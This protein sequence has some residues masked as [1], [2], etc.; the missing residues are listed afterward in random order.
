MSGVVAG[1][2][3]HM[4]T[5]RR[6]SHYNAGE[7]IAVRIR[8][9]ARSCGEAARATARLFVPTPVGGATG[10]RRTG[11]A[12]RP[13]S[14]KSNRAMYGGLHVIT[15]PATEP[16]T[17]DLARR[18][19]RIDADYD[20]DL[21]AM[22][23]E[24][25]RLEAEAYLNR[26]LFTQQ[27]QFAI[28]WA[29]PPTATPL[30]P[31]IVDRVPLELAAFGQAADR[32]SARAGQS[33]E[34]I[35]WGPLGD[36]QIA[37]PADYDLNLAVEPAYVAVKPQLL[38]RIPQQSMLIDFTAGYDDADP[39]AVPDADPASDPGRHRPLLR[40]PGRRAGRDAGGVLSVARSVSALDLR[41]MSRR[42]A[43]PAF[44]QGL[45]GAGAPGGRTM[46]DDPSG[47]YAASLGAL[48]WRVTLY[49][50]DQ[51]PADDLGTRRDLGPARDRLGERP[52]EPAFDALP[53]NADRRSGNAYD[54]HPLAG[55]SGDDRC[56]RAVEEPA[57][58]HRLADRAFPR[59]PL[60]RDRRSAPVHS[61]GA[62]TRA[63]PHDARRRRRNAQRAS[64]RTL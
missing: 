37:D 33:V 63:Q 48:R 13:G 59:P 62:R 64:Y 41:R 28:T 16:I 46:P 6:F 51:A 57:R 43:A 18:H 53:V 3:V 17:V 49:R 4:R 39:T 56:R 12:D 14:S 25:A 11:A 8:R 52:A 60:D 19:C 22:Y 38:P 42:P 58:R 32:A 45:R 7:L 10:I 55:L 15:P 9:G 23:I 54:R 34:Q 47:A 21:I 61:D 20:D 31:Q 40:E 26:A 5:L 29:P 44:R 24:G 36:M 2:L 35:T 27:L 30:V 1:T 50:R